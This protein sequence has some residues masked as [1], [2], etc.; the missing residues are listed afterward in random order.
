MRLNPDIQL[1]R[2]DFYNSDPVPITLPS[3][4]HSGQT[5]TVMITFTHAH[6]IGICYVAVTAKDEN[7]LTGDISNIV[8]VD[9][10]FS[11]VVADIP[12]KEDPTKKSILLV[13]LLSIS[14]S[15]VA[16]MILLALLYKYVYRHFKPSPKV[17]ILK[18]DTEYTFEYR[19]D[20]PRPVFD[21]TQIE[22]QNYY[23]DVAV[24]ELDRCEDVSKPI[25]THR[26]HDKVEGGATGTSRNNQTRPFVV[27]QIPNSHAKLPDKPAWRY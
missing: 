9:I 1:L 19:S 18:K 12:V 14:A 20:Q 16:L 17:A 6:C 13:L 11:Y 10:D 23:P 24:F 22:I 21:G 27:V 5:E 25:E 2:N 3:P 15:F 26:E 4:Q 7:D 8:N